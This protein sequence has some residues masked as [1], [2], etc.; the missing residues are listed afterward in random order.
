MGFPHCPI[1][2]AVAFLTAFI[3][4][5]RSYMVYL[6]YKESVKRKATFSPIW[7]QT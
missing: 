5:T 6:L 4:A 2:V 3:T 1:C 7:I